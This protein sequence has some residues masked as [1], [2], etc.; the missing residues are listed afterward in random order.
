[1]GNL[2]IQ[3]ANIKGDIGYKTIF[4]GHGHEVH[5]PFDNHASRSA[6][7]KQGS[8]ID[9][10]TMYQMSWDG[11]EHHPADGY[12]GPQGG[13]YPAP[14][15]ARDIYAYVVKGK[16]QSI[17]LNPTDTRSTEQR[18][19]D[20]FGNIPKNFSDRANEANKK[21]F[22]HNP[23]LNRWGNA[24]EFINGVAAGAANPFIGAGE[25]L[26]VNDAAQGVGFG[27]DLATMAAISPMSAEAAMNTVGGL[28]RLGRFEDRAS[29]AVRSWTAANPNAAETVEAALNAAAA[30]KATK[31]AKTGVGKTSVGDD[32]S[33]SYTCSFHGSTLVKTDSGYKAIADIRVG[34]S[35]FAKDEKNG[36]TG[37]KTVTAQYSNPYKEIVYVKISDGINTQT[38]IANRIH[39]F[40]SNGKWIQ[41]GRLKKGDM[42]LSENGQTQT[43]Q[44]VTIKRQPLTAYN[45]TVADWHTYFVKGKNG[46]AEAVWVHNDCP[47]GAKPS[48][49]YNRQAHYG[50]SQT[51]GSSALAARQ[52]GEG[53]PCPTCGKTQ[54]S[55][56]KTAPSPQHEPPLVKHYYEQGGH[57]MTNAERAKYARESINGTQCLTCQRK[58]GASMSRYSR[59]QA[60]KHGL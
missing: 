33:R 4:S 60:K 52:T 30:A 2:L 29:T 34:D 37:Y 15:G 49:R 17:K 18:F 50:G 12:D 21:M 19:A 39:P 26:G 22:E 8:V 35:V 3:Q 10:F 36:A 47:Y 40:Y 25:A 6:S 14:Q 9:G 58:E 13:G 16:A 28:S 46:E 38:V 53:K 11:Y 44:T 54:I 7:V 57:S 43:V 51:S 20:R 56:T 31:L 27:I 23:S 5:G 1:M 41:A 45:L 55:G 42:L 59:E 48:E 24:T 32:F